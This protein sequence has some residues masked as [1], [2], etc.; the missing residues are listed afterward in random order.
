MNFLVYLGLRNYDLRA[1]RTDLAERASRLLMKSRES[2]RAVYENY[3]AITSR[4][5][6]VHSSG[7]CCL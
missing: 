2:D 6:D 1:A 4:G 3:N 5:N 7:A